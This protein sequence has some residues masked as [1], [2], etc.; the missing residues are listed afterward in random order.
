LGRS[1]GWLFRD[2]I[3]FLFDFILLTTVLF[4]LC[5]VFH[6]H[7]L[8]FELSNQL[9]PI[10]CSLLTVE[11]VVR[12]FTLHTSIYGFFLLTWCLTLI[13]F[14]IILEM[15]GGLIEFHLFGI[16]FED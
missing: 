13:L 12:W 6:V 3:Q 9:L 8:L 5:L 2:V 7:R 14:L 15:I 1:Q 10:R 16:E 11:L 4:V